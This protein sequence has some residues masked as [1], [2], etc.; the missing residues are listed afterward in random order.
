MSWRRFVPNF[1][2]GE[3]PREK[4]AARTRFEARITALIIVYKLLESYLDVGQPYE[5]L[6]EGV[7]EKDADRLH[8]ELKK[9]LTSLDL[10]I[11]RALKVELRR[12][13]T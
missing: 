5:D 9:V 13:S 6:E 12:R 10:R 4:F 11:Q 7:P 1:R 2:G 8:E 3:S